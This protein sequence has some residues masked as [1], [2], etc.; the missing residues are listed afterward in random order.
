M[1]LLT[2]VAR[3]V[4]AI[5]PTLA[6]LVILTFVLARVVPA[7]P[8]AL[9]AGEGA[10]REQLEE[11]RQRHGFDKPLYVQL[12]LYLAQLTRGDLGTSLYT[13]RPVIDDL[14]ERFP[15]TLE[16]TVVSMVMATLVGVPLGVVSALKRN[17][18]LD[19]VLRALTTAGLAITGFWLGIMLQ[20]L[21]SMYLDLLPLG[22]RIGVPEPEHL[23]G[24]FILDSLLTLKGTALLSSLTHISLPAMTLA[25][26]AFATITRFT[27]SGVLDVIQ[28]E[29]ILYEK[30]M[31]LPSLLII[32][33]YLLRNAITSTVAQIGLLFG[34]LL[35]GA[36]VIERVYDWPGLGLYAVESIVKFDYKATLAITLWAG[37]A[38]SMANLVVDIAQAIIDPRVVER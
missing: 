5:V 16:L 30:A 1:R 11:L 22:G 3:R 32:G 23:T 2:Y 17:S 18:W 37:L 9:L 28:R 24:F 14:L 29:F 20:L 25:Y 19:H 27:R 7:D 8:A 38:Y 26:P 15:A 4:V 36:V 34:S 21:F 6:G 10:T 13:G 35:A 33:K 12:G 31:G